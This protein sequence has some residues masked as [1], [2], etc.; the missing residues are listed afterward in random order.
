MLN[1]YQIP[2][3]VLRM[4]TIAHL[5]ITSKGNRWA[6]T[7]IYLHTSDMFTILIKEKSSEIV[8]QAYLPGIPAHK[9]GS[10][11]IVS[12]NGTEFKKS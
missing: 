2:V 11:T 10:V 4:D 12:D 8:V 3:A 6:L 7:A 1:S 5:P 9:G